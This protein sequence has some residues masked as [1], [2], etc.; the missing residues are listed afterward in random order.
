MNHDDERTELIFKT[1]L[2]TIAIMCFIF[3]I[4]LFIL[5]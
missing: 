3:A 2:A 4:I 1:F 5:L